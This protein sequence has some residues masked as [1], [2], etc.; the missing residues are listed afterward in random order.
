MILVTMR[1]DFDDNYLECRDS[2]DIRW[3]GFL[4]QLGLIPVL[5]PNNLTLAEKMIVSNDFCGVL[6]TG[7]GIH[8]PKGDDQR[9]AIELCL[10]KHCIVNNLPIVGVCR[11]M[12]FIQSYFGVTLE[13][14]QGHVC[15]QQHITFNGNI[16]CVNSFHEN[17]T[18]NTV[19]DLLVLG[20]SNDNVIKAIRHIK[21]KIY[22]I[23]W[24]P[25]RLAKPTRRD[26]NLFKKW[27]EI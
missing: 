16:E 3:F 22:G 15:R 18:T 17:G 5:I 8:N 1:Q 10:I 2:I 12:Q 21:K 6:L 20:K 19:A 14:I 13:P 11:G 23:M 9:S 7:G 25:E 24:H 27:F 4:E 26:I